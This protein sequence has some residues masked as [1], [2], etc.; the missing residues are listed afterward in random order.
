MGSPLAAEM[1]SIFVLFSLFIGI[2][3]QNIQFFL[4]FCE[5]DSYICSYFSSFHSKMDNEQD[6]KIAK[7]STRNEESILRKN[8]ENPEDPRKIEDNK[9]KKNEEK[10]VSSDIFSVTFSILI[11]LNP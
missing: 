3:R 8:D 2:V 7:S 9:K 10:K 6:G 5:I 4:H 1:R 11:Q